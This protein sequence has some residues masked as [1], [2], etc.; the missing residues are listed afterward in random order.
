ME[1]ARLLVL[2]FHV[3]L[4]VGLGSGLGCHERPSGVPSAVLWGGRNEESQREEQLGGLRLSQRSLF[5]GLSG[6]RVSEHGEEG[7]FIA[8]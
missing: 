2:G 7:G 1:T 6:I 8:R 4:S 3:V 5:L